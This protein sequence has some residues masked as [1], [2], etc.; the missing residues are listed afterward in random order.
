M[1][2]PPA[3]PSRKRLPD[4]ADEALRQ[5]LYGDDSPCVIP[6]E[7]IVNT[8]YLW[9]LGDLEEIWKLQAKVDQL[10]GAAS[11]EVAA[12]PSC[13]TIA[14]KVVEPQIF[15][16]GN[17]MNKG[18]TVPRQFLEVVAGPE[19]KPFTHG[20]GRLELAQAIVDPANPLTVAR[21]GQSRLAAS[22]RRW[23]GDDAQ[24]FR[25]SL[26]RRR[27]IRSCSI[28]WRANSSQHGWSTKWLHRTIMLSAAYRQSSR[29]AGRRRRA[30]SG[31]RA[32]SRQSTAVAN[33][34]APAQLRA[35]SRYAACH[36]AA[37]S[38]TRWAAREST[39]SAMR[40]SVYATVDRQYLPYV[41]SVFDFANPDFHSSQRAETTNPQQ[42]LF[43]LNS[44][45]RGRSG[46]K[47]CCTNSGRS[48][49]AGS[50]A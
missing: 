18:E 26:R 25:R 2:K 20:S 22:L 3:K 38:T 48:A 10:A 28:G 14:T 12:T 36:L 21:L 34:P 8:E 1:Q 46:E 4:P 9:H 41:F 15:R 47:D 44:P 17:P 5:V 32:R 11:D 19:R 27:A 37:N 35:I 31:A 29:A 6:D 39:C 13:S 50:R 40:R 30:G 43:A 24:R 49:H 33:E 7:P 16:R 42:A 45:Y 23:A